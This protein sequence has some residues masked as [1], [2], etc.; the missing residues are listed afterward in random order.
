MIALARK[1][2]IVDENGRMPRGNTNMSFLVDSVGTIIG[3]CLGTSTVTSYVESAV[4]VVDG[5]RTGVVAMVAGLWFA[6]AIP[7]APLV[8]EIP[9]LATAPILVIVGAMMM[10]C[11]EGFDWGNPE[12]SLPAFL[13][14]LLI[15]LTFNIAYGIVAGT[16]FWFL[17]QLLLIPKRL[18][19]KEDPFVKLRWLIRNDLRAE[20]DLSKE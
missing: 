9:D 19:K 5:G 8:S 12:E 11:V 4:G 14:L 7:F 13:T 17:L 16:F 10:T 18:I 3:S 20:N 6:L 1:A 15:P 2:K